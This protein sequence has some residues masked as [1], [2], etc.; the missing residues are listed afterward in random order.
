MEMK[1][2]D[3]PKPDPS[4]APSPDVGV[5][6]AL[7]EENSALCDAGVQNGAGHCNTDMSSIS[8]S[9]NN[10]KLLAEKKKL[11]TRVKKTSS[12]KPRALPGV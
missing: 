10:G 5:T 8:I 12:K 9:T 11:V 7:S 1:Y 2:K 4:L 6:T 3:I